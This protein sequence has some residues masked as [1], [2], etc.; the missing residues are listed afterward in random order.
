MK[1][2]LKFF[3]A[4]LL[5]VAIAVALIY[6]R[7]YWGIVSLSKFYS[8]SEMDWNEDGHLSLDEFLEAAH[9]GKE[10]READGKAY[11]RFWNSKDGATVKIV[12]ENKGL[13]IKK[14]MMCYKKQAHPAW[15]ISDNGKLVKIEY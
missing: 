3:S 8:F 4:I 14:V 11:A 9:I 10:T 12:S 7:L 13:E 15:L 1:K 2:I 5:L 6:P